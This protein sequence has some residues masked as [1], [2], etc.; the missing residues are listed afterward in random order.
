MGDESNEIKNNINSYFSNLSYYAHYNSDIWLTVLIIFIVLVFTIYFYI[1]NS[2]Q[3]FK[4]NWDK[5]KCNPAF[6]PFASIIN[7]PRDGQHLDFILDNFNSCMDSMNK[8]LNNKIQSPIDSIFDNLNSFFSIVVGVFGSIWNFLQYLIRLLLE[9]FKYLLSKLQLLSTELN[10]LVIRI[11]AFIENFLS[12]LSVAY[13]QL[14]LLIKSLKLIFAVLA[15]GFWFTFVLP[16]IISVSVG[17]ATVTTFLI[18]GLVY[19][20]I[21]PIPF[22]GSWACFPS[23][24]FWGLW[25][26]ALLATLIATVYLVLVVIIHA[27]LNKFG[28]DILNKTI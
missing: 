26:L 11:T 15:V 3:S 24:M 19:G 5:Y 18:L 2:L 7:N 8:H 25:G 6:M 17:W 28:D 1:L 20:S 14:V 16:G 13:Y 9:L 27:I 23:G 21:C 22:F 4:S 10:L 12:M